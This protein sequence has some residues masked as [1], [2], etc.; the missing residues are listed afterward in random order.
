MIV[1]IL[2]AASILLVFGAVIAAFDAEL[3]PWGQ[4]AVGIAGMF[5]VSAVLP[6]YM[7][8]GEPLFPDRHKRR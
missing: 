4:L 5:A 8:R 7:Y 6:H 3:G 2:L 1:R